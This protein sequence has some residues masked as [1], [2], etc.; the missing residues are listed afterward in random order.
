[1]AQIICHDILNPPRSI[2]R[3]I[4]PCFHKMLSSNAKK[5]FLTNNVLQKLR[6]FDMNHMIFLPLKFYV[7]SKLANLEPQ[8]FRFNKCKGS[9]SFL[10]FQILIWRKIWVTKWSHCGHYGNTLSRIFG[11]NFVKAMVLLNIVSY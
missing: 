3:K 11:K 9:E 2:S 6:G 8:L 5:T 10:W 4:L 7:K 1:M